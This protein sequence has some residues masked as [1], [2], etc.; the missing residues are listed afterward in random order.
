MQYRSLKGFTGW[1]QTGVL[2]ALLGAGLILASFA[3]MLVLSQMD[4][5]NVSLTEGTDGFMDKLLQPENATY[6]RL[7]N[8]VGTFCMMFLPAV[9]FSWIVQGK[10]WFWMG[11]NRWFNVQQLIIGFALIFFANLIASPLADMTK[12]VVAGFPELN[13]LAMKLEA[14][15]ERQVKVLA[16]LTG[17]SEFIMALIFMALL[18]A[19]F[20]EMFFRGTMQTLFERWWGKPILA[21]VVTS[22]IFSLIHASV[23]LFLSRMILGVVLGLLFYKTRNLWVNTFVH[24]A[25][26]ALA[27]AQLFWYNQ[28]HAEVKLDD[29]D[30]RLPWWSIIPTVLLTIGGFYWINLYSRNNRLRIAEKEKALTE[31]STTGNPFKNTTGGTE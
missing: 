19:L 28:T 17:W 16:N 7:M 24:F 18:P 15:Y 31:Q 23:Y 27:A 5:M 9:L 11:F 10:N 22:L 30:P 25:N 3:Q 6:V 14:D 2:I 1:G 26:N 12:N 20:E 4:G 13:Q 29:I 8:A 21:I